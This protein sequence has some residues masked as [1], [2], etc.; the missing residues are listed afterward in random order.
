MRW[1]VVAVLVALCGQ[2]FAQPA[3]SGQAVQNQAVNAVLLTKSDTTIFTQT[4]GVYVGDA[5][6]CNIAVVFSQAP[7]PGS[8][9]TLTNIQTGIPMPLSITKLMSTNTT[10]ATVFAL[11]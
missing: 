10:C 8:A 6:A 7:P 5:S 9:V 1:L 4:K 3:P 2:S 11:Y